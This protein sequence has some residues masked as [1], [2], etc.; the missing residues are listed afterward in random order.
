MTTNFIEQPYYKAKLTEL[1]Y[2]D[3]IIGNLVRLQR[4]YDS[5]LLKNSK[6]FDAVKNALPY[7]VNKQEE[8]NG[9]L[10]D[11]K[12]YGMYKPT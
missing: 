6:E 3:E 12:G 5:D 9:E 11:L 7:W 4:L 2:I 10:N 8:V 1:S